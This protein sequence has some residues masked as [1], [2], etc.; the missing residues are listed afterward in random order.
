MEES[1]AE[2]L[3]AGVQVQGRFEQLKKR[4][5]PGTFTE[6]GNLFMHANA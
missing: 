5:P 2:D 4:K 3:S 1:S 6:Q